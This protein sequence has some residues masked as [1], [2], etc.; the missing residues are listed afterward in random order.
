MKEGT[1]MSN[2][3]STLLQALHLNERNLGTCTGPEW[4]QTTGAWI[5]SILLQAT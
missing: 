1:P 2:R 3:V 4:I 5:P